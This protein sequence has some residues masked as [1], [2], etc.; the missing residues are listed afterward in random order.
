MDAGFGEDTGAGAGVS[1]TGF[2]AA[3]AAASG[4]AADGFAG[5]AA[6]EAP[7]A[8][9]APTRSLKMSRPG[10]T[11]D[12]SSTSNCSITPDAGELIGIDVLSVSISPTTS[13]S[14]TVS[15]TAVIMI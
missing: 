14:R 8:G 9:A 5:D 7:A 6:A 3:A 10:W 15:P 11:V 12:P 13:S 1:F 4:F 2:A